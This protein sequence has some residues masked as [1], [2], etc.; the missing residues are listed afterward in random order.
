MKDRT[1]NSIKPFWSWNDKLEKAELIHQIE[2]MK[3]NGIEGFFMHARGGLQT[4][5][6]SDEWFD[7]IEACL[8]KADELG[9][10]AWAYDE[11]GWPS[12]AGNGNVSRLSVENQQ[13]T[14]TYVIYNGE[15]ILD[16]ESIIASFDKTSNGFELT[17]TFKKGTYVFMY[18]VNP[19]Y[20]DVFNKETIANFLRSTHDKYYERF[21]NRFGT[22]LRGFFTDEPQYASFPWSHIFPEEFAKDYG[23]SLIENLPALLTETQNFEA[24]RNDFYTMVS[25]LYRESFI[26]QLYDWCEAHNCMLTGHLMNEQSLESQMFSTGGVM[27]CYKYFHEPGIDHLGRFIHSPI[28]PKQLG[29]VAKQLGRKTMTETFALCGWDVSLNELKWIAQWQYL[30]GVTSLCPHLEGYSLRGCRKRDYPAS[31]FVQL[32]WFKYVYSDFADYF[33]SL[34]ALLDKGRDITP[35]LV[36]HPIQ[37]AYLLYNIHDNKKLNEYSISFDKITS[38]LNDNHILHHYGDETIIENHGYV[39]EGKFNIGECVYTS[40]LLPNIKN[41]KSNTV[42]KLIQ[43]SESGGKIYSIG[44][45]PEFSDGRRTFD[46]EKLVSKIICC[47]D[48]MELKM[49]ETN[50]SPVEVKCENPAALHLTLKELLDGRK[51]LY[52][53]NNAKEEQQATL[54]ISGRYRADLYDVVS[55]TKEEITTL[56]KGETTFININFSAMGSAVIYLFEA[57][58][59]NFVRAKHTV[60][61]ALD[62]QFEIADCTQN[63]ITLDKCIYRIDNGQWQPEIA[64][65]NLFNE[66]L[67]LRRPCNIEMQFRFRIAEEFDFSTVSLC[68]ENPEKFRILINDEELAF[69]DQGMFVDH[70]FRKC[71]IGELLKIGENTVKLSVEFSQSAE[72]YRAKFTAGVHESVLNK[73]TYDTELESIYIIGDFGV[74]MLGEYTLGERRCIHGAKDFALLKPIKRVDITDITRQNFWF[75]CGVMT[76]VQKNT[77]K[78]E[79]DKRYVVAFEKLNAPAAQVIVNGALAGNMLFSP[80]VV[81]VTDYLVDGENE[82]II[83]MLSGNRNL[84]G[85]HHR[86]YGESYYVGPDTFS[87]KNGW[88]DDPKLPPWTDNYNFVLFGAEL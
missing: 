26:K 6:M 29:S 67:A 3:A 37:S 25:R 74:E 39:E 50:V 61:L 81:D 7:L 38:E 64:V 68:M 65:I 55:E 2:E 85:P 80:F 9:M 60:R 14:L 59:S 73:L 8:D 63:A 71:G 30:N 78:K 41:L 28:L 76:L 57:D 4:Q 27:S 1:K 35:L 43:F 62:K 33:T 56:I 88:S 19:Y 15:N 77:V 10:Q 75:F 79:S 66:V 58:T 22:S 46:I 21:K 23:Y 42:K 11:N 24:V 84:L 45:I 69:E 12:G 54:E 18:R 48:I 34:G 13:K 87:S 72:L 31:L 16:T 70:S 82:I 5:Y 40:V 47:S 44:T 49:L 20:I 51:F 53:I 36:I 17:K 32:P 86:P 52:I 83:N